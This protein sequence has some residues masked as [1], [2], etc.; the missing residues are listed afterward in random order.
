MKRL[1]SAALIAGLGTAAL[2]VLAAAL[3]MLIGSALLG[4]VDAWQ[5]AL[6]SARPYLRVW[7]AL[8]YGGLLLLWLDLLR[9]YRQRPEDRQRVQRSGVIGLL[10][11]GAAELSRW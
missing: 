7:R 8:L 4:G 6:A 2:M 3:S 11:I 10:L 5:H 9:R 1:G